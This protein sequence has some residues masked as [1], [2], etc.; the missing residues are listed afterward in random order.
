VLRQF[1]RRLDHIRGKLECVHVASVRSTS[2]QNVRSNG[3]EAM[4]RQLIGDGTH[5]IVQPCFVRHDNYDGRLAGA[6]WILD[7]CVQACSPEGN[8]HPLVLQHCASDCRTGGEGAGWQVWDLV[9]KPAA[10]PRAASSVS[11]TCWILSCSH[12]RPKHDHRYREAE[13]T[14]HHVAYFSSSIIGAICPAS[15]PAP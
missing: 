4:A 12:E 5:P 13:N 11:S 10:A 1:R 6:G 14:H 3:D 9:S 2:R 15:N 8:I 7:P